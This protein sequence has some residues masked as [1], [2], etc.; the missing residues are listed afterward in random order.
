MRLSGQ[1]VHTDIV[2]FYDHRGL[3]WCNVAFRHLVRLRL[4]TKN[5]DYFIYS[6]EHQAEQRNTAER[7]MA[8]RKEEMYLV[9]DAL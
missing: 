7:E 2:G 8:I 9:V 1:T 5:G 3:W 6:K 4:Y